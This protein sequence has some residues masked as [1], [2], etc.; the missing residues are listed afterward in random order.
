V[1]RSGIAEF[2]IAPQTT[3]LITDLKVLD[4]DKNVYSIYG[5]EGLTAFGELLG[6]HGL[7]YEGDYKR[8]VL[9]FM[10]QS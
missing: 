9:S 5:S 1:N 4:V 2:E 10:K 7:I 3:N 6:K 8:N